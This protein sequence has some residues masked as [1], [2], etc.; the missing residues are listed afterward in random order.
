MENPRRVCCAAR[1]GQSRLREDSGEPGRCCGGRVA[2]AARPHARRPKAR[3]RM[4]GGSTPARGRGGNALK[5]PETQ[6]SSGR[7][8]GGNA[9]GHGN[10]LAP[11]SKAL[12]SRSTLPVRTI[13]PQRFMDAGASDRATRHGWRMARRQRASRGATAPDEEKALKGQEL[14][15]RSRLKHGGQAEEGCVSAR[16]S[17]EEQTV[18][19]VETRGTERSG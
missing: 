5:G 3:G 12:K 6:E 10:A 8:A 7:V 18:G 13:A 4:P 16:P 19:R 17:S 9:G 2:K 15:E 14:H 11:G 1:R